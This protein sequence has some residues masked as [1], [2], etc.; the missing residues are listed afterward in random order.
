[1]EEDSLQIYVLQMGKERLR[2]F[3]NMVL[4]ASV[5]DKWIWV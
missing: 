2:V 3:E 5:V 1:M 4:R